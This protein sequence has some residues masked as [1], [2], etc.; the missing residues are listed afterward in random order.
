MI[1]Y[2]A[3]II[4]VPVFITLGESPSDDKFQISQFMGYL[5]LFLAV[6]FGIAIVFILG[7]IKNAAGSS[8]YSGAAAKTSI[9]AQEKLS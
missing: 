6:T 5:N 4:L 7:T 3:A 1:F 2:L 9:E 8:V